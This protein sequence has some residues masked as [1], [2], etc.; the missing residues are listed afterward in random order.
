MIGPLLCSV[1]DVGSV[2]TETPA[3]HPTS[4]YVLEM[5][6]FELL[7]YAVV[8]RVFGG[9]HRSCPLL[10]VGYTKVFAST[11]FDSLKLS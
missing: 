11:F 3:H 5:S 7:E 4:D 6:G 2:T 8:W 1:F 10:F 9:R